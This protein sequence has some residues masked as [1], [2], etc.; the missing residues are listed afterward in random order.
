MLAAENDLIPDGKVG[1]VGDVIRDLPPALAR[2]GADVV[3]LV[4]AYGVFHERRDAHRV[5][6]FSVPFADA[7]ERVELYE[8]RSLSTPGVTQY[9][10]HHPLFALGGAGRIYCDD[11]PGRPFSR[12]A[13][14]FALFSIAALVAI[15][16]GHVGAVDV[17][18]LH[19]WHVGLAAVLLEFDPAFAALDELRTVFGIHNL[20]LQGIRPL[21]GDV[22]SL[23]RWFPRLRVDAAR[24]ADPRWSDCVNPMAAG[25]RLAD[26]VHTVSPTYAREI[27]RP[28]DAA[29]GFHGGEGLEADLARVAEAGRLA[30]ILNG[31]ADEEPPPPLDW[32]ALPHALGD[33]LLATLGGDGAL[34][35]ADYLAGR[36]LAR[37]S[38]GERPAHLLTV[39]GR[40]TG[41]KVALLLHR[42]PDGRRVLDA[43]LERLAA[44]D[45]VLVVL[46]TGDEALEHDCQRVAAAHPNLVFV[47][48]YSPRLAELLFANGDLLLMPSSFEPCGISQ[49]LAM[50]AGQPPLAHAVGGLADTVEDGVDG[51]VFGGD[52][53]HAQGEAL[54]AR[55][56]DALAL[57]ENEPGRWRELVAGARARR[58]PWRDSARRY[59]EELYV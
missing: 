37:W 45:G 36:R 39:V 16:D 58:F 23:E 56:D 15:R 49:M 21:G 55:L 54:L 35:A 48:R 33:A 44:R 38:E 3:V 5:R 52:S 41:Q 17:L 13:S 8:L 14:K 28:N 25:I 20:A 9:V 42:R 40:L 30:G 1:G 31:I 22:S 7:L 2:E 18:H 4:P 29:H 46:G 10:L 34:P 26:R 47:R 57:R 59:L 6:A 53:M 19:D 50:R 11:P 27:V 12:D 24:V 51:F 43:L 32:P